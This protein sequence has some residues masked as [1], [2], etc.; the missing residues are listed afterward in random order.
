MSIIQ[1]L[2]RLLS[3]AYEREA[4]R[5][6]TTAAKCTADSCSAADRTIELA[7]AAEAAAQASLDLANAA[8]DYSSKADALRAKSSEVTN[9]LEVK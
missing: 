8:R 6:D 5:A 2:V 9:F 3:Y 4:R 1:A 7:A